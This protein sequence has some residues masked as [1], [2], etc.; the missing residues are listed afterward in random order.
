MIL[1]GGFLGAGKTTL[2]GQ[3]SRWLEQRGLRVGLV[4]NDQGSA[5]MD[6]DSA[7]NANPGAGVEEITGGCFCC[8]LDDLV[9]AVGRLDSGS[10]PD[11]IVAEPVGSCTDLMATVILPLE[12]IYHMPFAISPFSVVLD[13]RRALATLG[14]KRSAKDFHR[15]V[16]YVFRKQIEEAEWLVVNKIDSLKHE[17]LMDLE[18]R[19]AQAYPGKRI[20]KVSGKTGEGLAD[21]FEALLGSKS[22]PAEIMKLDYE[23]Y[24]YGEALMG[25]VNSE[26]R[27]RVPDQDSVSHTALHN[28][29]TD[30]DW[31]VWLVEIG[32][33]IAAALEEKGHEV[34]HFKMSVESGARRWR[35]HQVMSGE[36]PSLHIDKLPTD[37]KSA[38]RMLV[39][40]RAEGQAKLLEAIVDEALNSQS[41]VALQF[42]ERSAFQ[43]GKPEPTHRAVTLVKVG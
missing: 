33:R 2:I 20:I 15:D 29:D 10:R 27:C 22:S 5:L 28:R 18:T 23:R 38:G 42:L 12:Q 1:I 8:R 34:G 6:T 32:G 11:V 43:P 37:S 19:L 30:F 13:A 24:A 14:G 25:W 9:G 36:K 35:L 16:G 21:W 41:I 3:F 4:T 39:N 17:D 40:L 7:R 26:A 31:G